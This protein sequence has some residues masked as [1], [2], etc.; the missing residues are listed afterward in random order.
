MRAMISSIGIALALFGAQAHATTTLSIYDTGLTAV[1]TA[2]TL[3]IPQGESEQVVAG[4]PAGLLA[5]SV[6]LRP[7]APDAT[8]RVLEQWISPADSGKVDVHWR[9]SADAALTGGQRLN[10]LFEGLAWSAEYRF[11]VDETANTMDIIGSITL[12]NLT[13]VAYTGVV[14]VFISTDHQRNSAPRGPYQTIGEGAPRSVE[15]P[16]GSMRFENYASFPLDRKLDIP[17]QSKKQLEILRVTSVPFESFHLVRTDSPAQAASMRSYNGWNDGSSQ[18]PARVDLMAQ[19]A[20]DT[21]SAALPAGRAYVFL[22]SN[23]V[24]FLSREQPIKLD[25]AQLEVALH[26][27]PELNVQR[28]IIQTNDNRQSVDSVTLNFSNEGAEPASVLIR[29]QIRQRGGWDITN[30]S[31]L[32]KKTGSHEIEMR[33]EIPPNETSTITYTVAYR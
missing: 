18:S 22:Q 27:A 11:M 1:S 7:A 5:S 30:S 4:L 20:P 23:G 13:D 26:A 33:A 10:Y 31:N 17:V 14:P 6:V 16:S 24:A 12:E 29:E 25:D 28:A 32:Y 8:L 9:V 2:L 15:D 19:L 21:L 3:E